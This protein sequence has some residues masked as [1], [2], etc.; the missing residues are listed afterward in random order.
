MGSF[1][2]LAFSF[3]F[4]HRS[5]FHKIKWNDSAFESLVYVCKLHKMWWKNEAHEFRLRIFVNSTD[6]QTINPKCAELRI[7]NETGS[8]AKWWSKKWIGRFFNIGIRSIFFF[9]FTFVL[10]ALCSF[11]L[12]VNLWWI[13]IIMGQFLYFVLLLMMC[14]CVCFFFPV[15]S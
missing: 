8:H 9:F 7:A 11:V 12:R 14:V 6:S 1:S 13:R 3:Y 4:I 2:T 5:L 15:Y 10:L